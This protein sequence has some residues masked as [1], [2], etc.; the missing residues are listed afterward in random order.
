M[1]RIAWTLIVVVSMG[2]V[3]GCPFFKKPKPAIG[4]STTALTLDAQTDTAAFEVWNAGG[5]NSTLSFQVASTT[6][7][8]S[9]IA[10]ATGSSTGEDQK[11]TVQVT[12]DRAQMTKEAVQGVIT[13]SGD[14]VDPQNVSISVE[15]D[16]EVVTETP[17]QVIGWVADTAGNPVPMAQVSLP[18]GTKTQTDEHGLYTFDEVT[19]GVNTTL[20]VTKDGFGSNAVTIDVLKDRTAAANMT[21]KRLA[22]PVIVDSE[23]ESE[24]EDEFGNSMKIPANKL[25]NSA[26]QPVTGEVEVQLTALDLSQPAELAAFP[27]GGQA[28]NNA[29][30]PTTFEPLVMGDFHVVK[31]G[32]KVNLAAGSSAEIELELPDGAGLGVGETV[33]LWNFDEKSGSWVETDLVGTV[34]SDGGEFE[35]SASVP[36]LSW[37]GFGAAVSERHCLTG[38]VVTNTNAPAAGAQVIATGLDYFGVS[39]ATTDA[40]GKFCLEVKQGSHVWVEAYLPGGAQPIADKDVAVPAAATSCE[41]GGCTDIGF[42]QPDF[43]ACIGGRV[44]DENGTPVANTLV[45]HSYGGNG[46]TDADGLF[47]LPVPVD[48]DVT[49]FVTGRPAVTAHTPLFPTACGEHQC[50]QVTIE[51]EYPEDGD[52]VG[53]VSCVSVAPPPAMKAVPVQLSSTAFFFASG[54][55]IDDHNELGPLTTDSCTYDV[56][57]QQNPPAEGE[58]EG[59]GETPVR[60][61]AL[62]PGAPG[63]VTDGTV[64]ADMLRYYDYMLRV[65]SE[66]PG[67]MPIYPWMAGM[68]LQDPSPLSGVMSGSTVT[69]GWPGGKDIGAFELTSD[70]VAP[71]V[72]TSPVFAPGTY[73]M[74]SVT[75]DFGADLNLVWDATSP[76]DLVQVNIMS[77]LYDSDTQSSVVGYISCQLVDDGAHTIPAS[78]LA[79]MPNPG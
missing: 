60:I 22:D 62:D 9:N 11:V 44:T 15:L 17:T 32:Q 29:G 35:I 53:Y 46:L 28:L 12:V 25:V 31:D 39:T 36:H 4:L 61:G 20:T 55:C 24:V 77:T 1:K 34:E 38:V 21:A 79:N 51:V 41:A 48:V 33:P 58:G 18:D 57:E 47:C 72:F 45:Y 2:C 69:L 3:A 14:G 6:A 74:N 63:W 30:A 78:Y 56:I 7:W 52:I 26:Q 5:K 23:S 13:V 66:Y 27:G 70:I 71:L 67:V 19:P 8:V 43:Q 76:G 49:V 73:G 50:T 37:W 75:I 10:P 42:L 40:T 68:F 65:Y 64:S 54:S 59:E 16:E